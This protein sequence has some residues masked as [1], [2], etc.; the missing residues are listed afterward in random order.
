MR[1]YLP[2]LLMVCLGCPQK[3]VVFDGGVSADAGPP[4]DAGTTVNDRGMVDQDAETDAGSPEDAGPG[5]DATVDGGILPCAGQVCLT[6]I[7]DQARVD[8]RTPIQVQAALDN[9]EGR[10]LSAAF[11]NAVPVSTRRA[12]RPQLKVEEIQYAAQ[13][14]DETTGA[15][16]FEVQIVPP[17]FFATDFEFEVCLYESAQ[18]ILRTS[19]SLHVRGNILISTGYQGVFAVASDGRPAKGL[20]A[21]YPDGQIIDDTIG[22]ATAMRLSRDGTLLILDEDAS[23][24]RIGRYQID[25][26]DFRLS[27]FQ[28]L[29]TDLGTVAPIYYDNIAI[30]TI[31]E[32]PNGTVLLADSHSSG[33]ARPRVMMW[34]PDGSF[35]REVVGPNQDHDFHSVGVRSN[36]EI[37]VGRRANILGQVERLNPETGAYLPGPLTE[38][39]RKE[40]W[41]IEPLSD[42]RIAIGGERLTMFVTAQGG[43]ASIPDI[44]GSDFRDWRSISEFDDR[45]LFAN[46]HQGQTENIAVIN[47]RNFDRWLRVPDSGGP[48]IV[49]TG[50]VYLE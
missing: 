36:D 7:P 21:L 3:V 42:G 41:A 33:T 30:F 47:G 43:A 44:P 11:C 4:V 24:P 6:L 13:I 31:A 14:T 25:S 16:T 9:P 39:L 19:V 17:W 27:T 34:N 8:V 5:M 10:V 50:M 29:A 48:V 28:H 46:D 32:M 18:E 40:I 22:R 2:L 38:D 26:A 20:N 15:F 1:R 37:L 35:L 23:P 49:P 45:V 12:G